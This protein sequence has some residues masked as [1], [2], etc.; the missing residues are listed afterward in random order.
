MMTLLKFEKKEARDVALTVRLKKTTM[1][2]LKKIAA[3]HS[4]SQTAII[5]SLIEAAFLEMNRKAKPK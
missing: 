4:A 3:I 2:K 1:D 5:E